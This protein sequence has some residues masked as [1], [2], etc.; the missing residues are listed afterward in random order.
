LVEQI[1]QGEKLFVSA[2]SVRQR[3]SSPLKGVTTDDTHQKNADWRMI[4]LMTFGWWHTSWFSY[5]FLRLNGMG[6]SAAPFLRRFN[7]FFYCKV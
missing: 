4:L 5:C 7:G 2:K 1:S 3:C 6:K